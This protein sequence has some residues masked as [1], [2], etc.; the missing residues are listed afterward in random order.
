MTTIQNYDTCQQIRYKIDDILTLIKKFHRYLDIIYCQQNIN[1]TKTY[2]SN[3]VNFNNRAL[4]NYNVAYFV[5]NIINCIIVVDIYINDQYCYD[6][7]N[8]K[9]KK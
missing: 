6:N 2:F 7:N 9:D 3:I 8:E 4:N 1:Q 5:E